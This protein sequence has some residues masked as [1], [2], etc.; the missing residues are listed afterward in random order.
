MM[1]VRRR[2]LLERP[3]EVPDEERRRASDGGQLVVVEEDDPAGPEHPAEVDEVDEDVLEPVVAVDE[4]DVEA[5]AL[6]E[7]AGQRGLLTVPLRPRCSITART[8]RT[9]VMFSA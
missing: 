3:L 8:R 7:E 2:D 1:L 6:G 9:C 4:C 5:A